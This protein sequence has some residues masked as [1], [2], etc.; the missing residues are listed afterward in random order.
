MNSLFVTLFLA[1][2][3]L[4]AA[5]KSLESITSKV[6]FDIEIDNKPAGRILMGMYGALISYEPLS[7][8]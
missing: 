5:K 1:I 2:I 8:L 3:V 4:A 6:Y 7:Y